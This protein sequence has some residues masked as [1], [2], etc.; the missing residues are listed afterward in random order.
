[1]SSARTVWLRLSKM[2]SDDELSES[3]R[4]ANVYGSTG[5]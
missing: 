1:M 3:D 2:I 5:I 4:G